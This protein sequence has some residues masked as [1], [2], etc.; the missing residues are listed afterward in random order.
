MR[1]DLVSTFPDYFAKNPDYKQFAEQAARTVE[2]PNVSNSIA[3]WQALRD[4][5]SRS[6]I[7]GKQD[8]KAALTAAAKKAD[9]LAAKD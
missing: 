5:Y 1:P 6:V 4:A 8:P 7:F 3:I 9:G 2:V